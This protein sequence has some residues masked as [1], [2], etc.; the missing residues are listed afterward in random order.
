MTTPPKEPL[1]R[2]GDIAQRVIDATIGLEEIHELWPRELLDVDP[3]FAALWSDLIHVV[4]HTPGRL[5]RRGVDYDAYRASGEFALT[6]AVQEILAFL[7]AGGVLLRAAECYRTV[8]APLLTDA[9][10]F[11]GGGEEGVR[12]RVRTRLLPR[13]P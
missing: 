13:M 8:V 12:A 7:E 11:S 2:A 10:P 3:L 4:E 6:R 1:A 5:F 9:E